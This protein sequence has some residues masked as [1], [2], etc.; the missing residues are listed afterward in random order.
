MPFDPSW[1]IHIGAALLLIAYAIR[2]ELKL[3]LLIIVSTFIYI[4]YYYLAADP[5]LWDAI[6]TSALMIVINIIVLGQIVLERTT[7][8]LDPDE[9]ALFDAFETL[10]P[11]Q[12][13]RIAKL[14]AWRTSDEA[15]GVILTREQEPSDSLFYIFEGTISVE[16]AD[17]RFR[18][19]EGNFV[20]EVAFVLRR[21]TTATTIAP[22][23][24]RFVEWDSKALRKL[25]DKYPNLGNALNALLTRDLA[26]KIGASYR[27]DDA[28]P[29]DKQ[30]E[31]L[32][33][34]AQSAP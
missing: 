28:M 21:K 18:L 11:G 13:R 31:A 26:R 1:L 33:E 20:G 15:D 5:P 4:A 25:S 6:I 29:A 3:R 32:L 22:R 10:T 27:P 12:F 17:R 16:K 19:P 2:D 30:S 14:A 8:R 24:V 23:G 34:T 9:K 7:F